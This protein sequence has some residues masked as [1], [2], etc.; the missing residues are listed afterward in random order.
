[1]DIISLKFLTLTLDLAGKLL[2]AV[3]AL[4]VHNR[5]IKEG[6]IDKYI[7]KE[8]KLERFVAY[9]AVILLLELAVILLYLRFY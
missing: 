5:I 6:R 9:I 3:M 2:L 4:L 7:L 8:M 1:M